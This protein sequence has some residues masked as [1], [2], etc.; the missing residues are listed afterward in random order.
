[1]QKWLTDNAERVIGVIM[2]E[3][4]KTYEDAQLADWS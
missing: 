3:T 1:M 4:G 2:S